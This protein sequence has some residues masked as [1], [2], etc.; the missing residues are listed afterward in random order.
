MYH[1]TPDREMAEADFHRRLLEHAA[2]VVMKHA[3]DEREGKRFNAR[4]CDVD[5]G[6][7]GTL[8]NVSQIISIDFRQDLKI[9][10][11]CW[12]HGEFDL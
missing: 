7:L 11:E 1:P 6:P 2:N 5:L 4:P 8:K 12:L 9:E 3:T 10:Y